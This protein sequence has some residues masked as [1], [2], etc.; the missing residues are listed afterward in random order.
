MSALITVVL[1]AVQL[2]AAWTTYVVPHTPGADDTPAVLSGLTA[3]STNATILFQKGITYN[4]FT[5]IKFP[6]LTNVEVSIQ[7]NLS[8]PTDIA[9]IQGKGLFLEGKSSDSLV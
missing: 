7:G 2:V 6:L 4:I 9:S 3:H 8:Y 1:F 5:P